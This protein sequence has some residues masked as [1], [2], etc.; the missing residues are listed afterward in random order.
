[1]HSDST[2][3]DLTADVRRNTAILAACM[4]L[5]WAVVQLVVALS[6]VIFAYLTGE[7]SLG[8]LAPGLYLMSWAVASFIMGRFMDTHGR[9]KGLRLGFAAGV[10][11][12]ILVHAGTSIESSVLFLFG[13]CLVGACSGT[14]NLARV[15]AADMYP[16]ARRARGISFVLLGAAFGAIAS[17]IAFAPMLIG[18][19]SGAE[20]AA[21]WFAAAALLAVGAVITFG[22]RI[23]P[24]EVGR[25]IAL[26][27]QT[28]GA[29]GAEPARKLREL[30]ALPTVLPAMIAAVLS[31]A[32]MAAFMSITGLIMVGHGHDAVAVTIVMSAHFLGM[33]GLVL[34][35]GQLVDRLGRR[36]SI[37]AGLLILAFG[38]LLLLA[39]QGMG[40]VL[41][42]LFIIGLGWNLAFVGS[43]AVLADAVRPLERARL[44][45]FND[46]A[47]ISLSALGAAVCALILG[48]AGLVPLV[49]V[50]VF[51][52]LLPIAGL[53]SNKANEDA[54]R[55]Q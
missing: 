41:P 18:A 51:L 26:R 20:L 3:K 6:A 8:G 24:I 45:G 16:P 39:G 15:G 27:A 5:S 53:L 33:F 43:T 23:D 13:L 30:I 52:S 4:G 14:V 42:A 37:I 54:Q 32:V 7:A 12:A 44:L 40:T 1:M 25:R 29:T 22:I 9:A 19:G 36:L 38:V 31:Q 21:P 17:P 46:F 2:S 28:V 35:A 49:L 50:G 11:G 48:L 47:A 55:A 34:V 10:A